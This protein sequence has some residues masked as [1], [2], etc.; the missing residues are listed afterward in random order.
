MRFLL[1]PHRKI[2]T[3]NQLAQRKAR[4]NFNVKHVARM[5]R[6]ML[7]TQVLING[8]RILV[9]CVYDNV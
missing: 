6:S 7:D 3:S 8:P 4:M 9:D 5:V 2:L 1:S